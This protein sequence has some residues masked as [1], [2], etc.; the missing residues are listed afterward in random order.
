LVAF[1]VGV[2]LVRPNY[3]FLSDVIAGGFLGVSAGWLVRSIWKVSGLCKVG[4][5]EAGVAIKV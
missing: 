1:A 3:H 4:R 2:G 5:S